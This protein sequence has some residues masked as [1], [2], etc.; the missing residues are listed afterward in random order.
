MCVFPD[1]GFNGHRRMLHIIENHSH[2]PCIALF[3]KIVIILG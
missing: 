1:D 3:G 2:A